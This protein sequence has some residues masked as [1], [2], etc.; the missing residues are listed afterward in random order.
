MSNFGEGGNFSVLQVLQ[1]VGLGVGGSLLPM[2]KVQTFLSFFAFIPIGWCLQDK[3]KYH[4]LFS[5]WPLSDDF[6]CF[7]LAVVFGDSSEVPI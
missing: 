7:F 3:G 1:V 4:V 5:L 2:E 6:V